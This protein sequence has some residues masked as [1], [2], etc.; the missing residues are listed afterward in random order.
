[1]NQ[2]TQGD[3]PDQREEEGMSGLWGCD[4]CG[5]LTDWQ[6]MRTHFAIVHPQELAQIH[7]AASPP[8]SPDSGEP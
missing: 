4:L 3:G 8:P 5:H 7:R 6:A 2:P 1:M